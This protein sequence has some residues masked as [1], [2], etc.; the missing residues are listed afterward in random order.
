MNIQDFLNKEIELKISDPMDFH[1]ENGYGPYRG[2]IVDIK[3]TSATIFLTSRLY[4]RGEPI[5]QLKARTTLSNDTFVQLCSSKFLSTSLS[6]TAASVS[7]LN[8]GIKL[9]S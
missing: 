6:S 8:G 7:Q 3:P 4:Y 1:V 5:I 9:I 2:R